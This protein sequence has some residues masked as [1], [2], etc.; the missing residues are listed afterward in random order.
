[1]HF[2]YKIGFITARKEIES[3]KIIRHYFE[4]QNYVSSRYADYGCAWEIHPAYRWALSPYDKAVTDEI[5]ILES[6][7]E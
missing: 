4:E 1:M 2:L 5:E 3:G 6:S 7:A